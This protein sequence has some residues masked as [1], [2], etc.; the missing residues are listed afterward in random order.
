ML[1]ASSRGVCVATEIGTCRARAMASMSR[2]RENDGGNINQAR[3]RLAEAEVAGEMT[4]ATVTTARAAR[5]GEMSLMRSS[6]RNWRCVTRVILARGGWRQPA[7]RRWL[8][9]SSH[10]VLGVMSCRKAA[11]SQRV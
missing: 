6:W 10:Q 11:K 7:A 3:R 4:A 9:L 2:A 1:A 5:N 8:W